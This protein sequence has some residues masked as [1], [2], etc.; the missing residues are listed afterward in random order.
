MNKDVFTN[1]IKYMHVPL[2]V[3]HYSTM[4]TLHIPDIVPVVS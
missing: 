3:E 1:I 2:D 4:I